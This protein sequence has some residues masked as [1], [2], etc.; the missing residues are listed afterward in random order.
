V[1]GESRPILLTVPSALDRKTVSGHLNAINT[2]IANGRRANLGPYVGRYVTTSE[3]GRVLLETDPDVLRA[4]AN[5]GL[6]HIEDMYAR[7]DDEE[8]EAE[9]VEV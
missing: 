2:F 4:S 3:R 6:A 5:F 8:E 7:R 1:A 9:E